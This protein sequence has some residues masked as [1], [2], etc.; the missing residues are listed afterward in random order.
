MRLGTRPRPLPPGVAQS[1]AETPGANSRSRHHRG[2]FT[3]YR[4]MVVRDVT[5]NRGV[6]LALV[7][8]MMLSVMLATASAG[9]LTRL[10]G[11]SSDLMARADAPHV[12]QLHAGEFDAQAVDR[13]VAGRDD[14]AHHQA[15]LLLGI[16][17]ANL[18]LDGEPQTASI[19]QNSL[20]VPNAERD[21]LL[22]LDNQPITAVEPGTIV[23]PV[24]HQVEADLEVG[25]T[26]TITA[27]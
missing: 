7:V 19:Q 3:L 13:W 9:T 21:L 17:G 23:P 1:R 12:A 11:A 26:V 16:D 10:I 14:V 18:F 27:P 20:V 4:R 5:R 6:T 15:M 25:D 24:Y 22:D 8:L 2:G